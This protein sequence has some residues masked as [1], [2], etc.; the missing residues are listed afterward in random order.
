MK[1]GNRVKK[2]ESRGYFAALDLEGRVRLLWPCLLS[3]D[4]ANLR[5]VGSNRMERTGMA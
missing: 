5:V 1:V 4:A 2:V 3:E